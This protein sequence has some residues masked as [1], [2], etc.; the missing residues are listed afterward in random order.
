MKEQG[1]RSKEQGTRHKE[2]GTRHKEQGTR[3]KMRRQCIIAPMMQS[4]TLCLVPS[5]CMRYFIKTPWWLKKI[6][7]RRVWHIATKEKII[8][9]TFDDGP[10]PGA[11]GFVLETLKTF[12]AK[13]TFFCI[14]KNV[15]RQ[16]AMYK[17]I[18]DEGHRVGNH[19]YH[20]YNGWKTGTE[21]YLSDV[22]KAAELINSDLFRPPY[23]RLQSSQGKRIGEAMRN[24]SAKIIMWD[25]LSGDFDNAVSGEKCV[26]YVL[27]NSGPGSIIV[28]HDSEKAFERLAYALPK[29]LAAFVEK[30]YRFEHL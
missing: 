2:K 20:H 28:F 12:N 11:T 27:E 6:Y 15:A 19:S 5:I 3:S 8:Y 24:R 17:R 13:A 16:P 26:Q 25:V 21:E 1:T 23:G 29:V 9:L 14:G 4:C 18:L 10:D 30:G 7:P 22:S